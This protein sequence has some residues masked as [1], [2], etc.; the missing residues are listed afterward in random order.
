MSCFHPYSMVDTGE[1]TDAGKRKLLPL[2]SC[3]VLPKNASVIE[4]PCGK[5]IGCKEDYSKDWATRMYHESLY[6]SFSY[7]L[8]ATYDD[9]HLSSPSLSLTDFQL[10]IK[11]IREYWSRNYGIHDIRYFYCGEYGANY[12]RPHYHAVFFGL[13][14]PD[15]VCEQMYDGKG[16]YTSSKLSDLWGKGFVQLGDFNLATASYVAQYVTKKLTSDKALFYKR[17]GL[18]PEFVRMS[19]RPGI[20]YKYFEDNSN[21]IYALDSLVIPEVGDFK[22]R[23]VP[24]FYDK[25]MDKV[26]PQAL[27]KTRQNRLQ[28]GQTR[29]ASQVYAYGDE[30]L[31]RKNQE[32]LAI[33]RKNS[34]LRDKIK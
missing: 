30:K 5:C 19:R 28:R 17:H 11:R 13:P 20:G 32:Y 33:N 3:N 22:R 24:R 4:V 2:S 8:T 26:N 34:N 6:H 21:V 16:V 23:R 9:A 7:F 18:Q 25:C 15:L 27:E 12:Q 1:F 29:V 31:M 10:Y 14:I